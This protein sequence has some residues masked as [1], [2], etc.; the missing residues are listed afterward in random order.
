[1]K[2]TDLALNGTTESESYFYLFD[3]VASCANGAQ[4][5]DGQNWC[6]VMIILQSFI[7]Y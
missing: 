7:P 2:E 6:I 4:C 3:T 5:S 1:L